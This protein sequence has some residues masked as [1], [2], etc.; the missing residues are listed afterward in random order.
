[1]KKPAM[2]T[3]ILVLAIASQAMAQP[4]QRRMGDGEAPRMMMQHRM[5]EGMMANRLGLTDEQQKRVGEL[6]LNLQR[7][8]LPLSA[9][10]QRMRTILKLEITADKYDA[11][12]VKSLQS[13]IAKVMNEIG[14]K[15]IGHQRAVRELLTPEQRTKFDQHILSGPEGRRGMRGD[16]FGGRERGMRRSPGF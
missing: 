14:T 7:E 13:D 6:R 3:M 8:I 2:I 15:R 11:A 10:L 1:M 5:G 9:E 12:K 4:G 16:G